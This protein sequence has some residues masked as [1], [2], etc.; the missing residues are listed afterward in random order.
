MIEYQLIRSSRK[1]LAI[2]ITGEGQVIVRAPM[3]C[4]RQRIEGFIR[5]KEDWIVRKTEEVKERQRERR[6][7]PG[8]SFT[9]EEK[10]RYIEEARTVF[11]RK[12]KDYAEKMGVTYGRITIREQKTR[13]GS[14]SGKG[15]LNF[16]WR[17]I[18]MPEPVLDYVVVHELAHRKEMNHSS[19]FYM[20]VERVMPEYREY[21]A[22][23]RK[24]GGRYIKR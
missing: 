8:L 3:R 5:E 23:L 1:T 18:L 20:E 6:T 17:L 21:Q 24:N 2:Q 22:W 7:E 19:R 13:W 10:S 16:N 9:E 14:C 12:V 11:N 4:S 15:N